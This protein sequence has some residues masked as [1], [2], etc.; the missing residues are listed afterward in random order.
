MAKLEVMRE[1]LQMGAAREKD[2]VAE[3]GQ[4]KRWVEGR[5]EDI[6]ANHRHLDKD[7]R[8]S[9]REFRSEMDEQSECFKSLQ[10]VRGVVRELRGE[11][12]EQ[13]EALKVVQDANFEKPANE[14]RALVARL[15]E[16]SAARAHSHARGALQLVCFS[17]AHLANS[18]EEHRAAHSKV[19]WL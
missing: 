8:A 12:E 14:A 1:E 7:L 9:L 15:E 5:S 19:L 11:V 4:L 13:R 3:M 18:G 17:W 10:D 16:A 2:F 6:L